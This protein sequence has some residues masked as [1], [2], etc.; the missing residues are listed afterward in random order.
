MNCT[1]VAW[2][3]RRVRAGVFNY[4]QNLKDNGRKSRVSF[5]SAV[6]VKGPL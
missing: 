5:V 2:Q 3:S 4:L 6:H 1:R